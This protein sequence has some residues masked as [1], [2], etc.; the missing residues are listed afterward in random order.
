MDNLKY[1]NDSF[2]YDY[3]I[4]EPAVPK[5]TAEIHDYGKLEKAK[6]KKLSISSYNF[7]LIRNIVISAMVLAAVCASLFLRAEISSLKSKIN[8]ENNIVTELESES[9]R[10]GVE[11]ERK[12]SMSNLEQSAKELG[13]QK[14]E[15]SQVTYIKT[16]GNVI[17]IS[18]YEGTT[19][20]LKE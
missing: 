10:L 5:K 15:K 14:C 1:Y 7:V 17:D 4:F 16:K 19:A 18:A 6:T 2:A 9:T 13:M 3:S 12:I 11:I 8:S 20:Q